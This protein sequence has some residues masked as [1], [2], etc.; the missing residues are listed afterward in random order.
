M[1]ILKL[2][3]VLSIGLWAEFSLD[4]PSSV[5]RTCIEYIIKNGWNDKNETLNQFIVLNIEQAF[6]VILEKI[7][8][9][10][11]KGLVTEDDPFP[12]SKI[13]L[14]RDNYLLIVSYIKYL[15]FSKNSEEA[16][17]LYIKMFEGFERI[18]DRSLLSLIARFTFEDITTNALLEGLKK[19]YYTNAMK[20]ELEIKIKPL[21]TKDYEIYFRTIS[22]ERELMLQM[23][24]KG[25]FKQ[26]K[27]FENEQRFISEVY[28]S[29]EKYLNKYFD[30]MIYSM[31]SS[32]KNN[33]QKILDKFYEDIDKEKKQHFSIW[34]QSKVY[35]FGIIKKLKSTFGLTDNR[36]SVLIEYIAKTTALTAIP[37]LSL[38]I[39]DY[40]KLIKENEYLL[41]E[42]KK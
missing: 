14:N 33:N 25:F 10:V 19:G 40:A 6:P 36:N 41:D 5:E 32:I 31:K 23:V 28:I 15:E 18:E 11:V 38:N 4:I 27:D 3:I 30:N 42:L 24:K 1:K 21:L 22:T 13:S 2:F 26:P 16:K 39:L 7:K 12:I 37:N 8:K 29:F 17:D 35:I 9:P 20:K 34:N